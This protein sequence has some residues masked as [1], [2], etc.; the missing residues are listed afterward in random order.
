ML[1]CLTQPHYD[2]GVDGPLR[3]ALLCL[4]AEE[5]LL[6]RVAVPICRDGRGERLG[7][8]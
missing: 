3:L 8:L 1:L 4:G 5:L 2:G 6:C 7:G